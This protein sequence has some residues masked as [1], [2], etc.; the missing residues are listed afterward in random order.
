MKTAIAHVGA[1]VV[2]SLPFSQGGTLA[3]ACA[4]RAAGCDALAGY[5]GAMNAARLGYLL[6]SGLAYSPVTFGGEYEDGPL[7]EL[8][9][10][11]ALG[12]PVGTTVWLDV[13][14]LKAFRT[15]P[16]LLTQK[17][18]DWCKPIAD[19]GF[20]PKMYVGVPQPFT[21]D[22]LWKLPVRGYWKGQGS[23]RDRFNEL[24]EPLHCGWM[25]NQAWPSQPCGG[26]MVDFNQVTQD[27]RQ[28]TFTWVVP[29]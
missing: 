14:G 20:D 5:L 8:A 18:V 6:E 23:V 15:D 19:A 16:K 22:E 10:L 11:R 13:E 4:L 21:S 7:D 29:D 3:Q 24:A 27:Y 12:V 28:R 9:Q 1:K 25:M 17:I 2:D 26:V